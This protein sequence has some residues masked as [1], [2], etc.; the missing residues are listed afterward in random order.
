MGL[1]LTSGRPEPLPV[2]SDLRPTSRAL[3]LRT[4][5]LR[6]STSLQLAR[7]H[8]S[9]N[10]RTGSELATP[11]VTRTAVSLEYASLLHTGHCL[12]GMYVTPS[13]ENLKN[14]AAVFFVHQGTHRAHL[15]LLVSASQRA[16]QVTTPTG[17]SNSA[18]SSCRTTPSARRPCSSSP[19]SSTRLSPS[20]TAPTTSPRASTPGSQRS[21]T[22]STSCPGS[23]PASRSTHSTTSGRGTASTRRR[24]GVSAVF[25]CGVCR[26][27]C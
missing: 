13:P 9:P 21:T 22:S 27:R 8:H 1:I 26:I 2:S 7:G 11:A 5:Y 10:V 20:R 14:R 15:L 18:S 17:S 3:H 25:V 23:K 12:L 19:T 16:V 6:R 24:T 4:K